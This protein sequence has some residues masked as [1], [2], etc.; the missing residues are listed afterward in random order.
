M[1]VLMETED[2]SFLKAALVL[3][4]QDLIIIGKYMSSFIF[5][6]NLKG[7]AKKL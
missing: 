4:F 3:G 6:V 7:K 2:A 5:L 1:Y